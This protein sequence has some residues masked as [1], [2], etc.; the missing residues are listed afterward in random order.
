[1][2]IEGLIKFNVLYLDKKY[3]RVIVGLF[4]LSCLQISFIS[5]FS[6]ISYCIIYRGIYL[7]VYNKEE[8]YLKKRILKVLGTILFIS[9]IIIILASALQPDSNQINDY[10]N[11]IVFS[12]A[13][14]F[15][16]S[17]IFF[18]FL[19]SNISINRINNR[20][21]FLQLLLYFLLAPLF[22]LFIKDKL[23]KK[24]SES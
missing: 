20:L 8:N 10:Q 16:M 2:N 18:I 6:L 22:V 9:S 19:L 5:Y 4:F 24:I 7:T 11:I 23:I 21:K 15:S 17:F 3:L 1:M 14:V 12:L 13:L